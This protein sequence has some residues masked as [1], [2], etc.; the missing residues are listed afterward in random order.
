MKRNVQVKEALQGLNWENFLFILVSTGGLNTKWLSHHGPHGE[1]TISHVVDQLGTIFTCLEIKRNKLL[2]FENDKS[3]DLCARRHNES[4][5]ETG[6]PNM[7]ADSRETAQKHMTKYSILSKENNEGH[8]T[9]LAF[10]R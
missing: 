10:K 3:S 7:L 5:D 8:S 1:T 9:R 6:T 2:E 4:Y